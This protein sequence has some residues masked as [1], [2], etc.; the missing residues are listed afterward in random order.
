MVASLTLVSFAEDSVELG[1]H[2]SPLK[3]MQKVKDAAYAEGHINGFAQAESIAVN[4]SSQFAALVCET[5]D[6]L[7]LQAAEARVRA[8]SAIGPIL[9]ALLETIAPDLALHALNSQIARVVADAAKESL[10]RAI[11]VKVAPENL[12]ALAAIFERQSELQLHASP[13]H[14]AHQATVEWNDG[15]TNIDLSRAIDQCRAIIANYFV[16]EIESLKNV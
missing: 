2:T 14:S 4:K 10:S 6:D 8:A 9:D 7:N 11:T 1:S 5:I 15:R 16:S 13:G 12:D 3:L